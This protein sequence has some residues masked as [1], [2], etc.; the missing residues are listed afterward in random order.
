MTGTG[1]LDG[2]GVV[3]TAATAVVLTAGDAVVVTTP[4]SHA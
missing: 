3:A 2:L 1:S 4:A